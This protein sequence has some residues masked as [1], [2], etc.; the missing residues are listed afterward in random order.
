MIPTPAADPQAGGT[1]D[2]DRLERALAAGWPGRV[3]E[4]AGPWWLRAADGFTKRANSAAAL[5]F[6]APGEVPA[7]LEATLAF[8]RRHRIPPRVHVAS[9]PRTADVRRQLAAGQWSVESGNEVLTAD[10]GP[11]RDRDHDRHR[12]PTSVVVEPRPGTAWLTAWAEGLHARDD[13]L[14]PGR[15]LFER[16]PTPVAFL[17]VVRANRARPVGVAAGVVADEILGVFGVAVV[18]GWRGRGIGGHLLGAAHAWGAGQGARCAAVQVATDNTAAVRLYQRAG[19]R[20]SHSTQ[21]WRST[22][23]GELPR[24]GA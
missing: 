13:V 24:P 6:A 15:A 21:F 11:D 14:E 5:G 17:S 19:Y 9:T 3:V 8:A 22:T 2:D 20:R 12:E 18:R 10:L 1:P 16:M 7:L 23:Q 4:R